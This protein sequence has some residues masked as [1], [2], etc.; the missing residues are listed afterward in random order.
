MIPEVSA[1]QTSLLG[2]V[3]LETQMKF[4]PEC[5]EEGDHRKLEAPTKHST[6]DE[7]PN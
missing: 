7:L 6:T 1:I 5:E 3:K 2:A 4:E